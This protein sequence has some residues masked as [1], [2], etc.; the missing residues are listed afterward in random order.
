MDAA[1]DGSVAPEPLSADMASAWM[2]GSDVT[3]LNHGSF[4]ARPRAV[5]EHQS[6]LHLAF[7][8]Q[9]VQ[10]IVAEMEALLPSIRARLATFVGTSAERVD[11]VSLSLIHI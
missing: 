3:Y 10:S 2:L 4:G 6:A 9:P 1:I 11:L 5:Y 8:Q 7:E